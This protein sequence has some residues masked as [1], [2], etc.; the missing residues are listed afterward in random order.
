M[1]R[2]K[3][4]TKDFIIV[5]IINFL[6]VLVFFLLMVTIA[7]FA[8]EQFNASTSVAGLVSS[9]FIIGALIGRIVTGRIIQV[10]GSKKI[11]VIGL[12]SVILTTTLYF[13]AFNLTALIIIRLLHGMS[14]GIASTATGTI[15]AQ[16][17][18]DS[19]KGEGIGY[20]SMS[21]ILATSVGPLVGILL[22]HV[23][24]FNLI[25][26]FNLIMGII[27]LLISLFVS[28][29]KIQS[30]PNRN[31][32]KPEKGFRLSNYLEFKAIPISF[33]ALIV[34]FGYSGILSFITFYGEEIHLEEAASYYFLTYSIIVLMSRPFSGRLMDLKGANI[35]IYPGL[36]IFSVGMYLLSQAHHGITLLL[37]SALIGLGFGNFQSV[38]QAIS[39]KV[40]ESHRLGLATSTYYVFYDVGLGVGPYFLGF[41]IP[42]MGF[43]NLYLMMVF[44]ILSAIVLYY[45]L[46][47]R[48]DKELIQDKRKSRSF[49]EM[50]T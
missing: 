7:G 34:G 8:V 31:L 16:I 32:I 39:I 37:A 3:L 17:V 27:T 43:R 19:R 36:L 44:V 24:G 35:I 28:A 23:S 41:L 40:T 46:H 50:T 38:A 48:K 6:L 30:V 9:I 20:F 21:A 11:L 13:A 26:S 29:S 4:W 10:K 14:I 25:F 33:V 12:I 2:E 22:N 42:V 15:I 47:G 18:P 45:F 1:H 49:N 5:S